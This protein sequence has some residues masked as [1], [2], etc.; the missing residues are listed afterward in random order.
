MGGGGGVGGGGGGGGGLENK[1]RVRAGR[2]G[3]E[4][5]EGEAC[6]AGRGGQEEGGG[7][8]RRVVKG[9]PFNLT[10]SK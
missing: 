7:Q 1:V 9:F 5:G 3:V 8:A 2:A 6:E 10:A 4:L